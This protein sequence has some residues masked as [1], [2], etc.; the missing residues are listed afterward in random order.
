[1][2]LAAGA[3]LPLVSAAAESTGAISYTNST[4]RF[5]AGAEVRF[6]Y[7]WRDNF[8]NKGKT[9]VSPLY[10]DYARL[11]VRPYARL[12]IKDDTTFFF[13]LSDEFR[14]YRNSTAD[15]NRNKFPD[16]VFIDNLYLEQRNILDRIDV[17][18]G[19][20][21]L[22]EGA[23]RV[24][25]DG[26]PGDGGRSDYFNA[27]FAK[28][29]FLK[30]SDVDLAAHY[31]PWRDSWTL[32]HPHDA[33]DLTKFR[34]GSPYSEMTE[35]GAFAYAHYNEITDLPLEAYAVWKQESRF[36]SKG[37]RYPGRQ[38]GTFGAR[39]VPK[40]ND[41]VSGE[42]EGAVQAGRTDGDYG[43]PGRDILAY[44]GYGGITFR[45]KDIW[46]KPSLTTAVLYLSG[47]KDSYYNTAD[48]SRDTG[49]NPAFNR[50]KWFSEIGAAMYD[51]LRWSNLIYPQIVVSAEPY[52]KNV[53]KVQAGPWIAAERDADA[54]S[55]YR[56]FYTQ[57]RY[58][59]PIANTIAG[60]PGKL[61]GAL[62]LENL[63]YGGYYAH[64]DTDAARWARLEINAKF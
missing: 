15:H 19:R 36:I 34:S 7:E 8:P 55:N 1:M 35:K 51:Q 52:A 50:T 37:K 28:V 56:G 25:A 61:S 57:V 39:A 22:K 31:T 59:F 58:E 20:Q 9:S 24:I 60:L 44:L 18:I 53:I 49:W 38:F 45:D 64:G 3:V 21:G 4:V 23:G 54:D 17:R 30:K 12:R 47:D 33:W 41:Y 63:Q 6:R 43:I 2:T 29:R 13:R 5:D 26:T 10:E 46:A 42:F 27:V 11:R 16:Q 62:V 40:L 32:G 48:G 14:A